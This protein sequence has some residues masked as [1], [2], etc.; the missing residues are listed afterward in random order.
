[1]ANGRNPH[2]RWS[3]RLIPDLERAVTARDQTAMYETAEALRA[4]VFELAVGLRAY[5]LEHAD[6]S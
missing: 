2:V 5:D 4:A 6:E 1:L 3:R